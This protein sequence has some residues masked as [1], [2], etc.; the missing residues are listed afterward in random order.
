MS[1]RAWQACLGFASTH[2]PRIA[3]RAFVLFS[4]IHMVNVN[5]HC[6]IATGWMSES[7]SSTMGRETGRAL[8]KSS[9]VAEQDKIQNRAQTCS[10]RFKCAPQW[11]ARLATPSSPH[12]LQPGSPQRRTAPASRPTGLCG[13]GGPEVAVDGL[14]TGVDRWARCGTASTSNP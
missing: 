5:Q 7:K 6:S 10:C 12:S 14:R 9:G 11:A 2:T 8:S 4:V 13:V 3:S 1:F